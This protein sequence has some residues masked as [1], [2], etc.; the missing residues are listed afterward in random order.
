LRGKLFIS[1]SRPKVLDGCP[2]FAPAYMGRERG[3]SNA[4]TQFTNGF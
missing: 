2:M 3:F 1:L 4:F